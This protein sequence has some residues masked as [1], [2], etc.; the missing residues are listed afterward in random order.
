[1]DG[2]DAQVADASRLGC[3]AST[4]DAEQW[5]QLED[6][7]QRLDGLDAKIIESAVLVDATK[8]ELSEQIS[9][10]KELIFVLEQQNAELQS[11][12]KR[13]AESSLRSRLKKVFHQMMF[14]T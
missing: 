4:A 5:K 7:R 1:M 6:H 13:L 14:W 11:E 9:R 8:A 3:E 10:L 2:L 12:V